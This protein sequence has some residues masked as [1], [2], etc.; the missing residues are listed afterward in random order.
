MKIDMYNPYDFMLKLRDNK[1]L[2]QYLENAAVA[3]DDEKGW[4]INGESFLGHTEIYVTDGDC[5]RLVLPI[6]VP[7]FMQMDVLQRI[8]LSLQ[9]TT[10]GVLS[11]CS[12]DEEMYL[13]YYIHVP[14]E[15]NVS[16]LD[17]ALLKFLKERADINQGF[18]ELE[19]EFEKM[20][21]FMA[22][23]QDSKDMMKDG[24]VNPNNPK[25]SS[26]WDDM[27][28]IDKESFEDD[29]SSEEDS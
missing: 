5:L 6:L 29:D 25:E 3:F 11:I 14:I 17:K 16:S 8:L 27:E 24:I 28:N 12:D 20:K 22:T 23:M 13:E 10:E 4:V 26:L 18:N 2:F 21:A 19:K 9:K 7:T 1:V 15:N